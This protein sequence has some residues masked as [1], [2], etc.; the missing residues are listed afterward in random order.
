MDAEDFLHVHPDYPIDIQGWTYPKRRFSMAEYC[1]RRTVNQYALPSDTNIQFF[2][3][4]LQFDVFWGTLVDTN[5]HKHQVID[6]SFLL[7]QS[8]M[9]GLIPKFETCGLYQFMGQR[10][11]FNEM[12]VKQFL[13]TS[14][15]D[16]AEESI[17]WMTGFKRY[18]AS[19][20]DFAA[21]NSLNYGTISAGVDLYNEDNFEDFVQF[22]EPA[23]LGIPRRF[24]ETAGLRHHPA[25]INKIA[26]VTILPKSGD[27]SKIRDKFWN[28]I[29]HIMNGEVMNIVLFMMRQLNDLKM[30]KNQNLA[31]A[32]Y[33]MALIKSKTRFEGPCEIVHTP[34]RP[35]KNEIGFLTRP[36]T[37][38]P[39]DEEDPGYEG[40][41][42]PNVEEQQMP[43]PP[44][45]PQ[46]QHYWE[47][48][49]G[50]FDPYFH[51]MQ[52]GLETHIDTRFEGLMSHVDHRLDDM[53]S[54]FD[55]NWDALNS[56]FSDF[57][58]QI[59]TNVTDPIMSRLNNMQQSFQ[60]N[61][62]ALSSQFDNLST[63]DNMHD[64][65]QRQQQLQQDFGQFSSLFD[66]FSTHYYNMHPPP[67]DQ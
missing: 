63:T 15:I 47:P 34:F 36:L 4:Q 54:R 49:P 1:S 27:K 14:E 43:P 2:H 51:N 46:P 5:F 56:E 53:Q 30:D 39:D 28:I 12:A 50:Y 37:P 67:S 52:Q 29:H 58:D 3:T 41:A 20:A 21:A 62:G 55:S 25:V 57:R 19:F 7:S 59:H 16:I 65:S 26:R 48:A 17:T 35:F 8:V 13:A 66:T 22:Y 64:I 6:W 9:E 32:P 23:R 60:D 31:Y 42:A 11:D 44:P 33:I 10:T 45:P 24:G 18:S 38:F 40:G 61:M